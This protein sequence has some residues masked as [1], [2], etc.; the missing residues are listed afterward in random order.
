MKNYIQPGD[1]LTIAAAPYAVTAGQGLLMGGL[2]GVAITTALI[3]AVVEVATKGVFNLTKQTGQAWTQG[4]ALYWDNAGRQ[5]TTTVGT[6]K[7]IGYAAT[8]Q[9]AGDT[10]GAVWVAGI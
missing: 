4:Q 7:L 5:V 9:A 8:A 3:N 6:N 1:R 10:V 2:F